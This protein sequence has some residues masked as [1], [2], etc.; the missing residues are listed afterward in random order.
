MP[1]CAEV[2]RGVSPTSPPSPGEGR[3]CC[4]RGSTRSKSGRRSPTTRLR[5]VHDA[6]TTSPAG[7]KDGGA[8]R[9]RHG[10]HAQPGRPGAAAAAQGGAAGAGEAAGAR[11]DAWAAR[12][13]R[14]EPCP[15]PRPGPL[16]SAQAREEKRWNGAM[17]GLAEQ[18]AA[19]ADESKR[20]EPLLERPRS[21]RR[22]LEIGRDR[23][24]IGS[25][26]CSSSRSWRR[27]QDSG[28]LPSSTGG[29]C[30]RPAPRSTEI[31]RG[32]PRSREVNRGRERSTEVARGDTRAHGVQ[33]ASPDEPHEIMD[34][35]TTL[36]KMGRVREIDELQRLAGTAAAPRAWRDP[37]ITEPTA[38]R[39]VGS[40][41]ALSP[42]RTTR[43]CS[44]TPAGTSPTAGWTRRGVRLSA[45]RR[46]RGRGARAAEACSEPPP[47]PLPEPVPLGRAAHRRV[48][49]VEARQRDTRLEAQ[50]AVPLLVRGPHARHAARQER[51][52]RGAAPATACTRTVPPLP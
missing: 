2:C 48:R 51:R 13:N 14:S 23:P 12:T 28:R 32:H 17:Q 5:H 25:T 29:S 38:G 30:R 9:G 1:R 6:S 27:R 7:R 26:C 18:V 3:R 41:S 35:A 21:W 50:R 42:T 15:H 47:E 11:R 49:A 24:R 16:L 19:S 8:R 46:R 40:R 45:P 4:S 44:S 10:R 36:G 43:S 39:G 20:F 31:D 52:R 33:A 22:S 37:S 34:L